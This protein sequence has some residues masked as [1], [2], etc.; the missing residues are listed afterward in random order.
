M[1]EQYNDDMYHGVVRSMVATLEAKDFYTYGHSTR[2]ADM[3][4]K[5]GEVLGMTTEELEL[6]HIAGD[7]HD[8]GKI[9]VPDNILNKP[10]SLE[11]G[12]W[13]LMKNHPYIGYNILSK[14]S[15][16]EDISRIVLYHHERWDGKGYPK[17]LKEEE[18]PFA[19]RILAVCDSIDAMKSDRP[20]R[21]SISDELCKDE[22]KKNK[23]IMYDSKIAEC[24]LNNWNKIVNELYN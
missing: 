17:G 5:L 3:A 8:I 24:M 7:L 9:G 1:L 22:I 21:K 23:G 2:V 11:V 14:T 20:Y 15:T 18:I 16:F 6:I 4:Y 10:D 12:E 19:S 13:E